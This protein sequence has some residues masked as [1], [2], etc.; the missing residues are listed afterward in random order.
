MM[1]LPDHHHCITGGSFL[2]YKNIF[3]NHQLNWG[4]CH[5]CSATKIK[6][7]PSIFLCF[8]TRANLAG[9][10]NIH[11]R[12]AFTIFIIKL[13]ICQN[14]YYIKEILT[15]AA[16]MI[17]H[18]TKTDLHSSCATNTSS[19]DTSS[20]IV[21]GDKVFREYALCHAFTFFKVY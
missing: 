13:Y 14:K 17:L 12:A 2:F 15:L 7:R 19:T 10:Q 8:T 18:R 1:W 3:T 11:R 5:A 16:A 20:I 4:V 9:K 6:C 21:I